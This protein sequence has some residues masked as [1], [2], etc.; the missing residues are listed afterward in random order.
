MVQFSK[1]TQIFLKEVGGDRKK[2]LT[3]IP[4]SADRMTPGE[5]LIFRYYL[6]IGPGSREQRVVLI[7]KCKRGD[8]VFPGKT[9]KLVSCFKL[10][11]KSEVIIDTI[12]DNLYKK[13]R[14]A[15]YYGKIKKSLIKILGKNSF[16]TYKLESMKEIYK[17]AIKV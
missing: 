2:I 15:S 12:L 14:Q 4:P 10:D 16:R 7:V 13:R 17:L 9:G 1:Q 5:V 6:G 8:G 3:E 11:G